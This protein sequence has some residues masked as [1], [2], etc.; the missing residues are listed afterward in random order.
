MC[1]C[2]CERGENQKKEGE[3]IRECKG[4]EREVR[5]GGGERKENVKGKRIKK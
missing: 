2:V 3:E 5:A 4:K 1:F